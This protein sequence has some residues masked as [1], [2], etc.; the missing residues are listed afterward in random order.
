M[1]VLLPYQDGSTL[2]ADDDHGSIEILDSVVTVESGTHSPPRHSKAIFMAG[3]PPHIPMPQAPDV[4]D[5]EETLS[6]SPDTP[7]PNGET[8]EC[9]ILDVKKQLKLDHGHHEA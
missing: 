5:G 8:D 2:P 4:Q 7:A 6:N 1:V 3:H 9:N